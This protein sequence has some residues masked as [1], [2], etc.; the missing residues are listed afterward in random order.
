MAPWN[1]SEVASGDFPGL[2]GEPDLQQLLDAFEERRV[3]EVHGLRLRLGGRRE[4]R[5]LGGVG[6]EA[7]PRILSCPRRT[8][9]WN[10][11]EIVG[12]IPSSQTPEV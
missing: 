10:K 8:H 6:F 12:S 5:H 1:L 4:V 3:A 7:V 9:F 2:V 11:Q